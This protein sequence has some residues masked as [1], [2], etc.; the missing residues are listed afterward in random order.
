MEQHQIKEL[1]PPSFANIDLDKR[2]SRNRRS[3]QD[4]LSMRWVSGMLIY[5]DLHIHNIQ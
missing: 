3:L 1:S 5:H 4:I 2:M